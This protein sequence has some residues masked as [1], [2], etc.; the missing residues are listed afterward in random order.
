MRTTVDIPDP[1]YRK[2]KSRASKEGRSLKELIVRSI[3]AELQPKKH[4]KPICG[5]VIKT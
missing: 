5:P 3:Q 1:L 2:L 4:V